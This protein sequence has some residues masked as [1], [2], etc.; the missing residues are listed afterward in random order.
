MRGRPV[1]QAPQKTRKTQMSNTAKNIAFGIHK[2]QKE[3]QQMIS[4]DEGLPPKPVLVEWLRR[5]HMLSSKA[6]SLGV[7][8]AIPLDLHFFAALFTKKMAK[9]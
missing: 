1:Y 7:S 2:M 3:L 6:E 5:Y 8:E 9:D 4:G